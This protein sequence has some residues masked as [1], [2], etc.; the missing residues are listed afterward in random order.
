MTGTS[1]NPPVGK[2][3]KHW[4]SRKTSV[5]SREKLSMIC[6][7]PTPSLSLMQAGRSRNKCGVGSIVSYLTPNLSNV[8]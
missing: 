7:P 5:A 6:F 8:G 2:M 4:I 3:H 1:R